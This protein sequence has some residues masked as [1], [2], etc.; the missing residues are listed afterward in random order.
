MSQSAT[1]ATR[2][3]ATTHLKPPKMTASAKNDR[4]CRTSHRHGHTVLTRT[5]A[6]GCDHKRN[7][8]RTYPHPPDPQSEM[9]TL[10]THSGKRAFRARLPPIVLFATHYQI[11]WNVTKCHVCHAK[12][13]WQ[14]AWKY[15]KR[16]DFPASPMDHGTATET[17][18]PQDK[19]RG[20]RQTSILYETSGNF[21]SCR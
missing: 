19:T 14:P 1:P 8:E 2:N 3:E 7:A 21:H 17:Q 6:N 13:P 11:G 15:S 5:V 12:T 18:A 4:L 9:G 16:R 10:A 20:Y